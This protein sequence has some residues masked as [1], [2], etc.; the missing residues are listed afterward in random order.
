M[1]CVEQH[2][3]ALTESKV[4]ETAPQPTGELL[5]LAQAGLLAF[6]EHLGSD[7]GLYP[8]GRPEGLRDARFIALHERHVL[9]C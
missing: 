8:R 9:R 6:P 2:D 7:R 1:C 4:T 5:A 3:A